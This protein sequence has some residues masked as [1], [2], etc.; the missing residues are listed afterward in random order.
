M[1]VLLLSSIHINVK[2]CEETELSAGSE[3]TERIH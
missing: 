3:P 1:D 2:E